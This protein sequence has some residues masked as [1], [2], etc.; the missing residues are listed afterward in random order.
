MQN[1][2]QYRYNLHRLQLSFSGTSG[3]FNAP[4][5]LNTRFENL[6]VGISTGREPVAIIAFLNVYV[7]AEFSS[8]TRTV[9]ASTKYASPLTTS[10]LF[11][12]NKPSTPPS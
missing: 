7:C 2:V 1:Q 4:V 8:I 11:P 6:N 5:E 3:K 10:T 9:F 12:F